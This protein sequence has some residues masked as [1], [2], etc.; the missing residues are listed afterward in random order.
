MLHFHR[1]DAHP[2]ATR[3]YSEGKAAFEAHEMGKV[4]DIRDVCIC[5][6]AYYDLPFQSGG[7]WNQHVH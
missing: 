7:Y 4:V 6:L 5:R 1:R 2:T 3:P